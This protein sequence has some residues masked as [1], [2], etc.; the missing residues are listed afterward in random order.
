MQAAVGLGWLRARVAIEPL[1]QLEGNDPEPEV[2]REARVAL[3]EI[4][5]E[6]PNLRRL[7][8][9]HKPTTLGRED[10]VIDSESTIAKLQPLTDEHR[11]FLAGR[12]P[13]LLAL[14]YKAVPLLREPGD[15]L[16]IAVPIDPEFEVMVDDL[17]RVTGCLVELRGWPLNL[18]YER[19]L[20]FYEWG[21]DDWV[22]FHEELTDEALCEIA[23][24]V[25]A[26][27]APAQP[28]AALPDCTDS[29]EA[30]QS[31]LSLCVQRGAV[32]AI[33]ER[34]RQSGEFHIVL[35]GREGAR[36]SLDPPPPHMG[37]RFLE[38][39]K[40]LADCEEEINDA[41]QLAG[42]GSIRASHTGM[43]RPFVAVVRCE[44]IDSHCIMALDFVDLDA[45]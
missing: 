18:I 45:N 6:F 7:L 31:F 4:L 36:E 3:E 10:V 17:Q 37:E 34:D 35:N 29:V 30:V 9:H 38:A 21:D 14:K 22:Q 32:S 24:I 40:L 39:L 16:V 5:R 33:L 41:G 43:D 8:K 27:I 26:A 11:R 42:R 19:L 25:L 23:D 44:S 28:H 12:L 15:V 13:R 20:T 1:D 2:R